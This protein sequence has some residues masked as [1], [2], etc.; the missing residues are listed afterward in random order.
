MSDNQALLLYYAF[1]VLL[2]GIVVTI[3]L[4]TDRDN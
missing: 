3:S 2:M 4:L 1:V